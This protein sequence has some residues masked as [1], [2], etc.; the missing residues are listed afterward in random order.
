MSF[1]PDQGS[2]EHFVIPAGTYA[3]RLYAV[4]DLGH[5]WTQFQDKPGKWS[6]QVYVGFEIPE[7]TFESEN[8]E[9]GEK[10][11]KPRVIGR[12]YTLSYY[13]DSRLKTLVQALIGRAMTDDEQNK[14]GYPLETLAG[15]PCLLSVV[16]KPGTRDGQPVTYANM[17][18]VVAPPKGLVVPEQYNPMLIYCI[19]DDPN[20]EVYGRLYQWLQDKIAKSREFAPE[21]EAEEPPV[22]S[23]DVLDPADFFATPDAPAT[24]EQ[25]KELQALF[26]E[27]KLDT[28]QF[29]NNY[30]KPLGLARTSDLTEAQAAA[31]IITMQ[32]VAAAKAEVEAAEKAKA[33]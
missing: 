4:V 6:H 33:A 8:K 9:T 16:H 29:F 21:P 14:T 13:K 12:Q 19:D 15:Q 30:V 20:K 7:L 25:K 24:I 5:Q 17:D 32:A 27:A 26:N 3:A 18:S 31:I 11:V 23:S 28:K 2:S 1:A 22:G 10:V